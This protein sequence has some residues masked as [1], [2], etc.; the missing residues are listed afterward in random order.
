MPLK[1]L[2]CP[3]CGAPLE[4]QPG[5]ASLSCDHCGKTVIVPPELR[6]EN[7]APAVTFTVVSLGSQETAGASGRT[8]PN[9]VGLLVGLFVIGVIAAVLVFTFAVPAVI[10]TTVIDQA[11]VQSTAGAPAVPPGPRRSTPSPTPTLTP[12]PSPTP[13]YARPVL[14][15]GSEGIGPGQFQD[16]RRIAVDPDGRIYVGEYTGGRIQVFDPAGKYQDQIGID[17]EFP[18]QGLAVDRKGAVYISQGGVIMRY[19]GQSLQPT[20]AINAPRGAFFGDVVTAADGTLVAVVTSAA[21][22]DD[23]VVMDTAGQVL[24]TIPGAFSSQTRSPELDISLAVD[25]VGNIYAL[26]SFTSAV[27]RFDSQGRF[28]NRFG[29]RGNDPGQFRSVQGIAVDGQGRVY[30]SQANEIQV[31]DS[32]GRYLDRIERLSTVYFGL[33][34]NDRDELFAAGRTKVFQFAVEK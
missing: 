8:N 2:E 34:V 4:I 10:M 28:T 30:V 1:T 27:F 3:A 19:D 25:G 21:S 24:R 29:S 23:I 12:E 16:A 14:N 6:E 20:G 18:L 33:A 31:F 32:T 22:P 13:G 9:R 17:P 11:S 5:S 7:P 15:F 26:G